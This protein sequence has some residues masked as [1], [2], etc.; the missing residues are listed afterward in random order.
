MLI[1]SFSCNKMIGSLDTAISSQN[2][3]STSARNRGVFK[4]MIVT[5]ILDSP[6]LSRHIC[7][8][9]IR[10]HPYLCCS[11][12]CLTKVVASPSCQHVLHVQMNNDNTMDMTAIKNLQDAHRHL[13]QFLNSAMMQCNVSVSR[14]FC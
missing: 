2:F 9:H 1:S 10:D 4:P 13:D 7:F 14:R 12:N 11:H 8:Y 6:F 3:S 5:S